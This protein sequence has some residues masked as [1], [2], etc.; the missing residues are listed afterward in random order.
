MSSS[1]DLISQLRLNH[2]RCPGKNPVLWV[3]PETFFVHR[4][5]VYP[6]AALISAQPVE[7]Q[8]TLPCL[9]FFFFLYTNRDDKVGLCLQ[10]MKDFMRY[11]SACSWPRVYLHSLTAWMYWLSLKVAIKLS[12]GAMSSETGASNVNPKHAHP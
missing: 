8:S 9:G 6:K 10:S 2:S 3:A 12:P 11:C 1:A 5:L 4:S 7:L